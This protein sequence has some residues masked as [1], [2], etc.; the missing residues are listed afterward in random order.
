M[1]QSLLNHFRELQ[2]KCFT[3]RAEY[4]PADITLKPV[5]Q[6]QCGVVLLSAETIDPLC[7]L[8]EDFHDLSSLH[9]TTLC[10]ACSTVGF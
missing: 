8:S 6:L 3:K 7:V 9:A 1:Y 10:C 4:I 2:K 5:L